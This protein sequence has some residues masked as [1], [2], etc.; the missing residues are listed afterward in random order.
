MLPSLAAPE[1]VNHN[2]SRLEVPSSSK[3]LYFL[4][5]LYMSVSIYKQLQCKTWRRTCRRGCDGARSWTEVQR[6][7]EQ[8]QVLP[9]TWTHVLQAITRRTSAGQHVVLTAPRLHWIREQLWVNVPVWRT[10]QCLLYVLFQQSEELS[11][12]WPRR[13]FN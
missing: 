4:V 6:R 11:Q 7:H 2:S 8:S 13:E 9:V 1:T 5:L 10:K 12:R 3:S